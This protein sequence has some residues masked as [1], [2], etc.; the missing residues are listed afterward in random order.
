MNEIVVLDPTIAGR[1][2]APELAARPADLHGKV[3]GAL[4]NGR[5][6]E[7]RV[8]KGILAHLEAAY[9]LKGTRL[10]RKPQLYTSAPEDM[11]DEIVDDCDVVITGVGT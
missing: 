9:R 2:K 6:Q 11:I 10:Y 7:D 4:W 8:L 3:V 5:P 1:A